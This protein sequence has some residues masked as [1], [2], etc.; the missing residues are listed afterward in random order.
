MSDPKNNASSPGASTSE[1]IPEDLAVEIR[2]MAHELSNALEVIVQTSYLLGTADLKEPAVSWLRM[3][4]N[5]VQKAMDI[6]LAL[7][8][9][10]KGHSE[11]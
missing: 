1:T 6:N 5:G 9:Y 2:K 4:D 11:G 3:M 7:R 10:I 8:N